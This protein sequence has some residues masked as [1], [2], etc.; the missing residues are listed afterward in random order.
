MGGGGRERVRESQRET[1]TETQD[2]NVYL[3]GLWPNGC[4]LYFSKVFRGACES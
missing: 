4:K 2:A 1:E 3:I